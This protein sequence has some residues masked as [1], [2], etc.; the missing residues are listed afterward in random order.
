MYFGLKVLL[1]IF[2]SISTSYAQQKCSAAPIPQNA[3]GKANLPGKDFFYE[4]IPNSNVYWL[5]SDGSIVMFVVTNA[6]VVVT[7]AIPRMTNFTLQAIKEVTNQS[8]T[9]MIYSHSHADHIEDSYLF[10]NKIQRIAHVE[11]AKQ[12][13]EAKDPFRPV[14]TITFSDSLT[15]N[16]GGTTFQ[17]DYKGPIHKV[18]NILTWL[19]A[20]KVLHAVDVINPGWAPFVRLGLAP[21]QRVTLA[22]MDTLLSYPFQYLIPGHD[23]RLGTK[24]D[25]Q[26][27]KEY[28]QDLQTNARIAISNVTWAMVME[29]VTD[30]NNTPLAVVTQQKMRMDFCAKLT[31]PKWVTKL[32]GADAYTP[33]NCDTILWAQSVDIRR[34][35][36]PIIL[37]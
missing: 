13:T 14:P 2:V 31:V 3:K 37:P 16:I 7:D 22:S 27:M 26:M 8:V 23:S 18:G 33:S 24:Q 25:V 1:L 4:K 9:Y 36:Q 29:R 35:G 17:F 15:M 32:G 11:T 20:S 5:T 6:G 34:S 30:P 21:D 28:F 12:L 10:G 19:P